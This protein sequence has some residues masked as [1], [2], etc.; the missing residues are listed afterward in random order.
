MIKNERQYKI[1]NAQAERFRQGLAEAR[2][3]AMSEAD[4][5]EL[6][7]W[8]LHLSALEG[9]LADLEE[10]LRE[11]QSLQQRRNE[12]MEITSLD[13]LPAILIK[14]RIASGL[15]QKQLA[16]KLGLKEQQVQRYE[17]TGYAGAS[18]QRIQQVIESLG[19]KSTKQL[20]IPQVPVTTAYMFHRLG[21]VG[22][23]EDFVKCK[24]LSPRLRACLE[25]GVSEAGVEGLVF[26]SIASI[27]RIFNWEPNRFLSAS[28]LEIDQRVVSSARFKMPSAASRL[29]IPAY[30][31]YAH[32]LALL[33]VQATPNIVPK[34][35]P[36]SWR[37][38]RN[39]LIDSFGE[40]TLLNV[41][42][43]I[44]DLGVV[45]LPLK[46]SG[47]FHAATWRVRGRNVIVIKQQTRSEAR[48]IVD[49]LHELWHAA[50]MPEMSEHSVVEG[51]PPY[52]SP[53]QLMEEQIATDF[54]ADVVFK[55]KAD[56]LAEDC[57]VTSNLRT[58]WLKSAVQSVAAKYDVRVDMLANYMAYRLSLEGQNWW[59]TAARLQ[60]TEMDPWEEVR[61]FVVANLK[62]HNL[63]GPDRELL[64]QA[65]GTQE[66]QHAGK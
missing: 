34:T 31:V 42:R 9:Q 14:A 65:L 39:Q 21:Q 38:V 66:F 50:Q 52:S 44:W 43:Y 28:P 60:S 35:I 58:E 46:D 25:S 16:D 47:R 45:I 11:Y 13:E 22:L 54:A 59:A 10:E 40:I 27:S 23:S 8:R 2:E 64:S 62:W 26:N 1:T 6:L 55:G 5:G 17:A 30:T 49:L 7:K 29:G 36:A 56:E 33:L 61:D 15:T 12:S 19:V 4:P 18:L 48:W 24:L 37:H 41:V 3:K 32:Y 57:A 51:E 63:G 20:F 53:E